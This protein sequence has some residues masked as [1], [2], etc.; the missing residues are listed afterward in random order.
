[1]NQHA[2]YSSLKCT[3]LDNQQFDDSDLNTDAIIRRYQLELKIFN[4]INNKIHLKDGFDCPI[5][6]S[7][8]TI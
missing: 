6:L 4:P 7:F 3:M 8:L 1:M 5:A 2:F